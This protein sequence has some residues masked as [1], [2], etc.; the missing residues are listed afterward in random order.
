MTFSCGSSQRAAPGATKVVLRDASRPIVTK[1]GGL[2]LAPGARHD[3]QSLTFHAADSG[4]GLWQAQVTI[5][6]AIV[7]AKSTLDT[8]DGHCATL[9]VDGSGGRNFAWPVPCKQQLAV[10]LAVDTTFAPNGRHRLVAK[11]WDAAGNS[12]TVISREVQVKNQH[13][14]FVT[15]MPQL[16]TMMA[17]STTTKSEADPEDRPYSTGLPTVGTA[18]SPSAFGSGT[19]GDLINAMTQLG[20]EQLPYC[21]GGGHGTSPAIPSAGDYCWGGTPLRQIA[22]GHSV[23]LDCSSSVSTV[24]QQAGFPIP[25]MTSGD[26][27]GW[28]EPGP[29]KHVTIGANG[30]HVFLEIDQA[31]QQYFWGTSVQNYRHG[32]NWTAPH[33]TA[34]FTARH[35]PGL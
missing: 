15:Q 35:P 25:T 3:I 31:G 24:L 29:G 30:G 27:A 8:N 2:I 9:Q 7:V 22:G 17:A 1:V 4:S 34:G 14:R 23:G 26:F 12:K 11:I 28:G 21:W 16:G 32:P 13:T 5:G 18:A 6:G 20:D 10:H 33:P 19:L